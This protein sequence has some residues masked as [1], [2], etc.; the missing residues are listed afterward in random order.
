MSAVVEADERGRILL[1]SEIRR[2][3]HTR[4]FKLTVK[5]DLLELQPLK[6]VEDLK[7]KYKDI[8]TSDWEKLEERSE[9]FVS[10]G[11]R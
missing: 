5:E 3:F 4:R 7:G 6:N 10:K 2:K 1:P 9:D 11:R 8:I